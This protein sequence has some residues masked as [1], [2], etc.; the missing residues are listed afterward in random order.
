MN[1]IQQGFKGRIEWWWYVLT[2]MVVFLFW[3]IIGVIP[4][5]LVAYKKAGNLDAFL[6]ASADGFASLGINANF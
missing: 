1:F 3:Q 5:S 4:I 2:L 6:N